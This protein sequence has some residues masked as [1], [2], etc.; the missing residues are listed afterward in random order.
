[1]S[2]TCSSPANGQIFVSV[3]INIAVAVLVNLTISINTYVS[4]TSCLALDLE[5]ITIKTTKPI[6]QSVYISYLWVCGVINVKKFY[7]LLSFPG[8]YILHL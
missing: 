3:S 8:E 7:L 2:H 1:M 6:H 4:I 5:S